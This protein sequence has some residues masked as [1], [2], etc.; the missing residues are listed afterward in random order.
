MKVSAQ[1]RTPGDSR[2]LR[3]G[4]RLPGIVYNKETNIPVSLELREFDKAFRSQGTSSIINLDIDGDEHDVLVR[5]VQMDK[6]RRLPIHID[7]FAITA[8]QPVDVSLPIEFIGDPI[9]AKEG[10]QVDIQ[11]REVR[12]RILPRLIPGHLE[13]DVSELA[14]ND[15]LHLSDIIQKLPTQAE[16]LDNP[17][18]TVIAILPPRVEEPAEPVE[19]EGAEPEVIGEEAEEGEEG[20]EQTDSES[21]DE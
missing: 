1:K 5:A 7:F 12:I 14:I 10:G 15:S 4:G 2:A 8:N 19:A 9:G 6:R 11:R 16:V 20:A 21:R 18:E 3:N 13:V 17:E